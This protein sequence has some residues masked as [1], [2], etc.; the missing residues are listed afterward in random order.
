MVS[1]RWETCGEKGNISPKI[2]MKAEKQIKQVEKVVIVDETRIILE[3]SEEQAAM[4][5]LLMG[6]LLP[7]E[8]VKAINRS[9]NG[10][11]PPLEDRVKDVTVS[12]VNYKLISP[13]YGTL[14]EF[15]KKYQS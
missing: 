9:L 8:A 3:M 2:N 10:Y 15:F 13:I 14:K 6:Q 11:N 4:L 7:V 5:Y 12:D 1:K